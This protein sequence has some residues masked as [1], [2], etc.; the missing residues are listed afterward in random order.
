[1]PTSLPVLPSPARALDPNARFA[2]HS[3]GW[4]CQQPWATN[5]T[6]EEAE[7]IGKIDWAALFPDLTGKTLVHA[8]RTSL[9]T[10]YELAKGEGSR[11]VFLDSN[12]RCRIHAHLGAEAKPHACRQF[13]YLP[14]THAGTQRVG[15]NFGCRAV[16]DAA[17]PTLAD[18]AADVDALVP[19]A[20]DGSAPPPR[21][22]SATLHDALPADAAEQ[23]W[24]SLTDEFDP[25]VDRPVRARFECCLAKLD[26]VLSAPVD[27]RAERLTEL[28]A[29]PADDAR[30]EPAASPAA[31]PL[32]PRMLFA[33]NLYPDLCDPRKMGLLSRFALIPRLMA[34]TQLRGAYPSRL[35]AQNVALTPIFATSP[36]TLSAEANTLLSRCFHARLWQRHALPRRRSIVAALHQHLLDFGTIVFFA[37]AL[38]PQAVAAGELPYD[39]VRKAL[40]LVEFHFVNQSRLFDHVLQGWF[41]GAL[42]SLPTAELSLALIRCR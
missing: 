26:S 32:P 7:R 39:A 34:V 6:A 37:S 18:Q 4:C 13:P 24:Q 33:A 1:M 36:P 3:C 8:R 15:L 17:G 12:Q 5:L 27:A 20:P 25:G 28:L 14:V 11:C 2:C 19:A 10:V 29:S 41:D 9:G 22:W 31:L 16:Q 35:L 23:L 30:V 38:A 42:D 40:T 21:P